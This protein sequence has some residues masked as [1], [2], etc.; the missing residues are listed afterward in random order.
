MDVERRETS[1]EGN[2]KEDKDKE[3]EERGMAVA[4]RPR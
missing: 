1:G 4:E 3:N 2:E